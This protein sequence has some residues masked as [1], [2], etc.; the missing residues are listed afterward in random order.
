MF[1]FCTKNAL[2][3]V[4]SSSKSEEEEGGEAERGGWD[5]CPRDD[6]Q[7]GASCYVNSARA[8]MKI[9]STLYSNYLFPQNKVVVVSESKGRE[10]ERERDK[11]ERSDVDWSEDARAEKTERGERCVGF[12]CEVR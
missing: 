2:A 5:I 1:F 12:D 8:K 6:G 7:R 9:F 11:R 10:R 3:I 4:P